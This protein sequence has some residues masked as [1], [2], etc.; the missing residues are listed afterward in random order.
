MRWGCG[1][2][3]LS[4]VWLSDYPAKILHWVVISFS[5]GSSQPKDG[6]CA[7]CGFCIGRQILCHWAIWEVLLNFLE[8][9]KNYIKTTPLKLLFSIFS[10]IAELCSNSHSSLKHFCAFTIFRFFL[11]TWNHT[12]CGLLLLAF[13]ECNVF[14]IHSCCSFCWCFIPF[15]CWV[16]FQFPY[17][18]TNW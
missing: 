15:F 3:V 12:I 10:V 11:Y 17:P 6:T 5:R 18:F 1:A 13:S 7:S 4:C 8:I 2:C 9:K 16:I 14:K